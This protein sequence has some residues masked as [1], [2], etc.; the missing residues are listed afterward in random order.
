[1]TAKVGDFEKARVCVCIPG[2]AENAV[3]RKQQRID[4]KC[5]PYAAA[6]FP[7]QCVDR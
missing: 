1:M 6:P 2:A 3:A 4:A 5:Q 7:S